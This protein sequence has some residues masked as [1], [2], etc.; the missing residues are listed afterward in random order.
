[1]KAFLKRVLLFSLLAAICLFALSR[2]YI[3]QLGCDYEMEKNGMIQYKDMPD[4]I[5]LA[6]FGN[7]HAKCAVQ[8]DTEQEQRIFRFADDAQNLLIDRMV[9]DAYSDRFADGAVLLFSISP[10]VLYADDQWTLQ[11][12]DLMKRYC[13]ILPLDRLPN[14]KLRLYRLFRAV[15]FDTRVPVAWFCEQLGLDDSFLPRS[16]FVP[17]NLAELP[18]AERLAAAP[19][20]P[21]DMEAEN[22][23]W[24][25]AAYSA[26]SLSALCAMLDACRT[27][28]WRA[29]LFTPPYSHYYTDHDAPA[30]REK[31]AACI[32]TLQRDYG[33][34][35]L[36]YSRDERFMN[37]LSYYMDADHM[38]R[39]GSR[40][41]VP[42]LL[43]DVSVCL[44]AKSETSAGAGAAGAEESRAVTNRDEKGG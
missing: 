39:E 18:E 12:L 28:G 22:Q 24:R 21:A 34:P 8:W 41:F 43:A 16:S 19:K 37:T 30:Y 15:D 5:P 33:V 1:M 29:V 6:V 23:K 20:A 26:S 17:N 44:S 42:I 38:N 13:N 3:V 14:G 27:N 2:L 10:M 40:A 36:D 31:T 4:E 7:S 32:E 35:Y 25:E 11:D 9:F